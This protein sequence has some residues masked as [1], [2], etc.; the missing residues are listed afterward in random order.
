[1]TKKMAIKKLSEKDKSHSLSLQSIGEGQR[2]QLFKRLSF[3]LVVVA[4]I[5]IGGQKLTAYYDHI[6][7][8]KTIA[9]TQPM[10]HL[11]QQQIMM[12]L[13]QQKVKGLLAI[14]LQGLQQD[15]LKNAWIKSIRIE[16]KWPETLVF[17][18]HEYKSI[19]LINGRYLTEVGN[20][21]SEKALDNKHRL[22]NIYYEN[23]DLQLVNW[24]GLVE[25]VDIMNKRL[26][27]KQLVVNEFIID[28]NNSWSARINHQF[29]LTFGRKHR[30]QRVQRFAEIYSAIEKPGHIR[31]ID[32]RYESGVAV[33]Y[34]DVKL[35]DKRKS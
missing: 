12:V 13:G 7:P 25:N 9:F 10:Q 8:V 30:L 17:S 16:N 31:S 26:A 15:I 22:L 33:D 20:L 2:F 27:A 21:L 18:I 6:W 5:F 14:D 34:S 29:I 3:L 28:K 24:K 1:M 4:G 35:K 11:N 19:A 23:I 32:L